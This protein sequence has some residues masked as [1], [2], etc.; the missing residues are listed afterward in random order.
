MAAANS[1]KDWNVCGDYLRENDLPHPGHSLTILLPNKLAEC[2][3]LWRTIWTGES[4]PPFPL[5]IRT[6]QERRFLR[7][8][9]TF[10]ML[11]GII[12]IG[13]RA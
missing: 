6:S 13:P 10:R 9:L 2:G 12:A 4:S 1:K 11:E 5:L 8:D 7:A 3:E